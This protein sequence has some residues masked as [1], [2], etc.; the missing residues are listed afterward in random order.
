MFMRQKQVKAAKN[1]IIA[2]GQEQDWHG[3]EAVRDQLD[4]TRRTTPLG[5][6][7]VGDLVRLLEEAHPGLNGRVYLMDD[8]HYALHQAVAEVGTTIEDVRQHVLTCAAAKL[9]EL[10]VAD[11]Q[12]LKDNDVS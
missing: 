9:K 5:E 11:E 7:S 12:S 6:V 1:A 3:L 2:L 10:V 8:Y 4:H